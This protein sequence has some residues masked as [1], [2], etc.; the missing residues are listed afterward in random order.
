MRLEELNWMDVERYLEKD[1]R[2]MLVCGSTE[3]H[4]YLSLAT[5]TRIPLALADAASARSGVLVAPAMPFG[6]APY[7]LDYPGTISLRANVLMD[8]AEDVVRSLYRQGFRHMLWIN[9]HGGNQ[10]VL[11]RLQELAN[12]F[13]DLRLDWY[14]WWT[15]HAVEAIAVRHELK[16]YHASWLE[17]F[18]FCRVSEMPQGAKQPAKTGSAPS[19]RMARR[20]Y[21]DGVFG[22]FYQAPAAVMD[23]V[24]NACL[25]DILQL[26]DT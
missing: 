26:L 25:Q 9:G 23:E 7:F 16:M 2:I 21:G 4:G 12:Q 19:A 5:D 20:S 14:S 11:A 22:G 18:S 17:A 24:F 3:Q 8:V 13:E 6:S 1:R 15:S 10:A